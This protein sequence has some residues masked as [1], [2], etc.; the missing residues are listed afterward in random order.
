MDN[1]EK[2]HDLLKQSVQLHSDHT[3]LICNDK[4]ISYKNLSE[5]SCTLQNTLS[6]IGVKNYIGGKITQSKHKSDTAIA[7]G[8]DNSS[9]EVKYL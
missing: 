1:G 9:E 8:T 6:L 4:I 5:L 2:L 7:I 3:A